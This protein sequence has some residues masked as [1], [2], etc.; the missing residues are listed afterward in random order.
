R[1]AKCLD[2]A[3]DRVSLMEN[4]A[5]P[6]GLA[7]HAAR[8]TPA[9]RLPRLPPRGIVMRLTLLPA[10]RPGST[11]L[12]LL[13]PAITAAEGPRHEPTARPVAAWR[14]DFAKVAAGPAS[15]AE[16]LRRVTLDL[17]GTVPTAATTRAFLSDPSPAK[18]AALVDRLLASPEH[19]RHL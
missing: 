4:C 16:F 18:R 14:P 11:L 2:I 13:L 12:L 19:A 3:G 1:P 10:L 8:P 5:K 9:R 15:D 7:F 6:A 17:T